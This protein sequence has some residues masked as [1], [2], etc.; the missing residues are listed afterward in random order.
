MAAGKLKMSQITPDDIAPKTKPKGDPK[1]GF[2][3]TE[4]QWAQIRK[5]ADRDNTPHIYADELKRE[6]DS[7]TFPLHF[8]DFETA[9]PVIPFKHGRRP[10][11]GLAFQFSHHVVDADGR[12][13]HRGEY[14]NAARGGFPSYDLV[15]ELKTQLEGDSDTIFHYHSHANSY[16]CPI[17]EQI[18]R[19][20]PPVLG[21]VAAASAD[22]VVRTATGSSTEIRNPQSAIRTPHSNRSLPPPPGALHRRITSRLRDR[23]RTRPHLRR[24]SRHDRLWQTPVPGNVRRRTPCRRI[25]TPQ[26]LRTRHPRDGHDLRSLEGGSVILLKKFL[27]RICADYADKKRDRVYFIFLSSCS[28]R[29]LVSCEFA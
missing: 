22:G 5:A 21:G 27:P 15:R 18:L 28:C 16:L 6:M 9:A 14:L 17:R 10:Y 20:S 1:P 3:T 2:S 29:F 24:R 23:L 11:E 12:V 7:W 26:I 4:R 8:I 25:R 19:D 13:E